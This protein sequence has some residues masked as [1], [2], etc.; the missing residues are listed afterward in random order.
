[1]VSSS[2]G[3]KTT[4]NANGDVVVPGVTNNDNTTL[5]LNSSNNLDV[6]GFN[7]SLRQLLIGLAILA[8]MVGPRGILFILVALGLYHIWNR[9]NPPSSSS[10]Q[11]RSNKGSWGDGSGGAR[12]KG[13]KDLPC[14]PKGG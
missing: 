7:L 11:S 8:L 1:M 14:D 2:R 9:I 12:V 5:H 3:K 6:F 13:I 4:I 10:L